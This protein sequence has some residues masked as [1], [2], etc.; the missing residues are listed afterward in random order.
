VA[1][2]YGFAA[3]RHFIAGTTSGSLAIY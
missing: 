3:K 2:L 1:S